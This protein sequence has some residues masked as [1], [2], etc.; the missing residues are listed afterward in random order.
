[1]RESQ[2]LIK[3]F[4]SCRL[5]AYQCSAGVWTIGYGNTSYLRNNTYLH[6][7]TTA[8]TQALANELFTRDFNTAYNEAT[9]VLPPHTLPQQVG[10]ITSFIFN[11]GLPKFQSSTLKKVITQNSLN[12]TD[13]EKEF[14][15]WVNAGGK[16]ALGLIRRRASEFVLYSQGQLKFFSTEK[17]RDLLFS[18][19]KGEIKL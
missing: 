18:W 1:M 16:I 17:D 5:N 4:E 7:T 12:H 15:K 14:R 11:F 2:E 8:I 9:K 13:I 19:Q 6:K 10:A 3:H